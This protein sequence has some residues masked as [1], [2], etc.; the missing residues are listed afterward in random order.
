MKLLQPNY[1]FQTT[2]NNQTIKVNSPELWC[3]TNLRDLNGEKASV[4]IL[5]TQLHDMTAN[6]GE[7]YPA[8]PISTLIKHGM[9]ALEMVYG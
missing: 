8:P 7:Y 2:I 5:T 4:L 1:I 9:V 6:G 3:K